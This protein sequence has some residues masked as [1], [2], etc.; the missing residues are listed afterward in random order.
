MNEQEIVSQESI[1]DNTDSYIETINQMRQNSVSR[2]DYLKLKDENK[3]LLQSLANGETIEQP[4]TEQKRKLED[5]RTELFTSKN[6]SNLEYCSDALEL[7][8]RTLEETGRDIFLPAGH[9]YVVTQADIDTA[10]K[11]ATIMQECIDYADGNSEI[12]TN[13]LMRR[14]ND[15]KS[16]NNRRR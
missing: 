15:T 8:N 11:V 4:S 16:I 7:R 6:L 13:E 1:T 12:F 2:E 3:K 9:D 14:T 10:N 5:V